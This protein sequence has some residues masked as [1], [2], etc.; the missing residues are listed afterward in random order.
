M[1]KLSK[2]LILYNGIFKFFAPDKEKK[3]LELFLEWRNSMT[4]ETYWYYSLY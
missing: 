3:K 2:L 1:T 4:S